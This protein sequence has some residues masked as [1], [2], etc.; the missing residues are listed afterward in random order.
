MRYLYDKLEQIFLKKN[1]WYIALASGLFFSL[2][3][4]PFNA[5]LHPALVLFPLLSFV[6]CIPLFCAS[7]CGSRRQA[8]WH[9]YLFGIGASAAQFYWIAFVAPEGMWHLILIGVFLITLVEGLFYLAT[10][11]LFRFTYHRFPKLYILF[12]PALWVALEYIKTLGEI[13][14]PWNLIGYSLTPLLALSQFSSITGIF[15]MSFFVVA[16][17]CIVWEILKKYKNR[18]SQSA[19]AYLAACTGLLCVLSLAG[20]LRLHNSHTTVASGPS[21][22]VS[23]IQPN[24]DQNHWGNESLELSFAVIESQIQQ[25]AAN[26]PDVMIL[27]ESSLLC[28]LDRTEPLRNRVQHWVDNARTP[29]VTGTL[30]WD[31]APST[32]PYQYYVYNTVMCISPKDTL[33]RRYYKMKLVPFSEALPFEGVFPILS[34]VNLGEADFQ[35]GNTPEQFKIGRTIT[36]VPLVC[37]EII[38]PSFVRSRTPDSTNLLINVTNDG[39]FGKSSGAYQHAVMAQQRCIEN[40]ISLARCANSG[41]SMFVDPYGRYFSR[42]RLYERTVVTHTVPLTRVKTLYSRWGD[43]PVMCLCACLILLELLLVVARMF[44]R[45]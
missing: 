30:H 17:N 23:L 22:A 8:L 38:Y 27:P 42:S 11:M 6:I 40:G 31:F 41:F 2:G 29:L 20:W 18:Q 10:G 1:R 7:L 32:S 24:I 36:G 14:F 3:T 21:A 5:Q 25:A 4:P 12:F 35:R 43:Y 34:R 13:S 15:G 37:Y 44:R 45:R 16:G 33:H 28:Y 26:H 39:W 19:A 9:T